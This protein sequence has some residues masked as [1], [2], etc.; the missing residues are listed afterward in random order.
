ME[1]NRDMSFNQ[2]T[3]LI[4]FVSF[5]SFWIIYSSFYYVIILYMIFHFI[6]LYIYL[7]AMLRTIIYFDPI[8]IIL[9]F[10]LILKQMFK[11]AKMDI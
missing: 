6:V 8:I 4:L 10:K 3:N 1:I 2:H 11:Y 5:A 9:S 7:K